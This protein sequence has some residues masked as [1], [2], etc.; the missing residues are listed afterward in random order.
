M[1][2]FDT[3]RLKKAL[4]AKEQKVQ[5]A[6]RPAAQAGAQVLYGQVRINVPVGTGR[7][8]SAIYQ[9]FSQDFSGDGYATYHISWNKK[10][11]P[12]GHLIEGGTSRTPA[13][14]FL[15]SAQS[16]AAE[17]ALAEMRQKLGEVVN[18]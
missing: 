16:Q 8:K 9:V 1:F 3:K 7:L 5:E 2:D 4:L 17:A 13:Q 10:K 14:P 6:A 12:H 15:R 18:D 11:A